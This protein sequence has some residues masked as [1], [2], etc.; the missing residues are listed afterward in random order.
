MQAE[1]AFSFAALADLVRPVLPEGLERLPLPQRRALS[2]ALLLEEVE[3]APPDE[4]AIAFAVF[5]LLG[6]DPDGPLLVAVDD[7]QWLDAASAS[8]LAFALRRLAAAGARSP[9]RR[10]AQQR[11][12]G[13]SARARS[14]V[15]GRAAAA[16][17]ARAAERRRHASPASGAPRRLV[18]RPML[19]QLHDTSGGNPFYALELGRALEQSGG[20]TGAGERLAVPTSLTGLVSARLAGAS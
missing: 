4:R 5:Q 3:G 2:A 16:V 18:S 8:V 10:T 20:R 11:R 6:E 19:V 12:G 17:A 7:V 15:S 14:R 9:P 1:T 13:G